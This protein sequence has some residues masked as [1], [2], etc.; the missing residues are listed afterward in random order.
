MMRTQRTEQRQSLLND[1]T[2]HNAYSLQEILFIRP[3]LHV[4]YW[5]WIRWLWISLAC[6]W[7]FECARMHCNVDAGCLALLTEWGFKGKFE[8]DSNYICNNAK[9]ILTKGLPA[10]HGQIL[11]RA[12]ETRGVGS[13]FHWYWQTWDYL[14]FGNWDK[15][16]QYLWLGFEHNGV[17]QVDVTAL[18][19]SSL[20]AF[21]VPEII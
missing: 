9:G 20:E 17:T 1:R 21:P 6:P 18:N 5:L 15:G 10:V 7:A 13:R 3:W 4:V 14:I 12:L 8:S 16:R 11:S 19:V 2:I